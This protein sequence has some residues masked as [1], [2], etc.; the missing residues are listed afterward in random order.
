[1][2]LFPRRVEQAFRCQL[3]FERFEGRLQGALAGCFQGTDDHLVLAVFLIDAD[4]PLGPQ[5]H[6]V[7]GLEPQAVLVAAEHDER[8]LRA[9]VLER[10]VPVA[11]GRLA[12][13]GKLAL[14]PDLAHLVLEDGFNQPGDLGYAVDFG[15]FG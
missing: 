13:I 14:H 9:L 6:A 4:E 11:R 10:E 1:M 15:R 3:A 5:E 12:E 8:Q 2:G 7:L